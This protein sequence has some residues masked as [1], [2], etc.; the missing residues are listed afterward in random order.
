MIHLD[1]YITSVLM[2]DLAGHD[3]KPASYLVYVWLAAEQQRRD[4]PVEISYQRLAEAVGI[5]KSAAQS[6]VAWLGRRRLVASAKPRPTATPRY[7]VLAPW[8][9]ARAAAD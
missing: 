5:S 9:R 8:R 2:R 4:G 7:T 1:E 3:R 6:A